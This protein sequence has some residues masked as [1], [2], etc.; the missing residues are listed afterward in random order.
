MARLAASALV[1]LALVAGCAAPSA[2]DEGS[3]GASAIVGGR[4][5][6]DPKLE[7][8]GA[9]VRMRSDRARLFCT[10]TLISPDTILTAKHCAV[11]EAGAAPVV[12]TDEVYFQLGADYR[13]PSRKVRVTGFRV[14]SRD[15]GGFLG[16]GADVA[17]MTL[18]EPIE[19]VPLV[20]VAAG[21]PGRADVGKALVAVGYGVSDE[22]KTHGKRLSGPVTL[23]AT[24]GRPMVA[25][26]GDR[27]KMDAH[28][29]AAEGA[30]FVEAERA[31]LDGLFDYTLLEGHEVYVG[32]GEG[33]VQPCV[34]DSGGPLLRKTASG[35]EIVAVASA[36]FKGWKTCS[37][38]GEVYALAR[39]SIAELAGAR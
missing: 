35:Y 22:A 27:K 18:A 19:G 36:S 24:T 10:A 4:E 29:L 33:D 26:F 17:V 30:D 14:A 32:L 8:V 21:V 1:A 13:A 37:V 15:A 16:R 20:R 38:V 11:S 7:G 23:R 6:R 39:P 5:E 9:L 2:E 25:L 3:E 12:E 31:R 34:G 28:F